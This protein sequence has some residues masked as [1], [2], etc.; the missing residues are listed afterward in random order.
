MD[1]LLYILLALILYDFSAHL[2]SL[3]GFDKFLIKRKL[4]WWPEI[5]GQKYQI[6]WTTFWGTALA[7]L[8]VYIFLR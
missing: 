2:A 3:L 7:T 4:N 6:F 1:L 5:S 8:C